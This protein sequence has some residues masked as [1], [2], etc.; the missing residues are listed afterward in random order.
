MI[1]RF[2]QVDVFTQA[3]FK[4][5]PLAVVLEADGLSDADMQAIARWTNLSETT[6][7]LPPTSIEADYRV[8]IFTP[9]TELPF[10]GHPTLGTAHAL[11]ESGLETRE[12]GQLLQECAAGL[13][14]IE[15]RSDGALAFRA[16][17]ADVLPLE[18][19]H[20]PTL[21]RA[22]AGTYRCAGTSP[23]RVQAGIPWLLVRV[24]TL[25]ACLALEPDVA[26][27]NELLH[28]CNATGLAI[29]APQPDALIAEYELRTFLVEHGSLVEDPVTGSA[30][31]CLARLLQT[32]DFPD[33]S[34]TR[35]G[36]RARQG[37]R[38]HRDGRVSVIYRSGDPWI[39]GHS[40][41]LVDGTLTTSLPTDEP[42][43]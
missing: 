35:D 14:Q 13:I 32:Q 16:P 11:L 4:G 27:L 37:T 12:P 20:L 43:A 24:P 28:A 3:P 7:V 23:T 5:N 17:A 22:L 33:G 31:A 29:Y 30:N 21:D 36:Y 26:A 34:Q 38:L 9:D 1:R 18:D 41:T 8:R 42:L 6:F 10:A 19:R 15:T 40:V 2:K 25:E 39:G